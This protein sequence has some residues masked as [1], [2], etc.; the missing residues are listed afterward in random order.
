MGEYL[1][2]I[3]DFFCRLKTPLKSEF[4]ASMNKKVLKSSLH[5]RLRPIFYTHKFIALG[6][7]K[8]SIFDQFVNLFDFS[9]T[10]TS[11]I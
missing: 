11:Q 9:R 10:L 2:H 8:V 5:K 7:I 4:L 6:I 3:F 1:T